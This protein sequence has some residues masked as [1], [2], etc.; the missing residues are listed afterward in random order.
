MSPKTFKRRV[1]D[2]IESITFQSFAY[3]RRGLLERHKLIVAV[4][5]TL[6]IMVRTGMISAQDS[7]FL[8]S[9]KVAMDVPQMPEN[10]S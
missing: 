4:M 5:L 3:I 10:L 9:G 7:N 6:R 1:E 2:L 8:I